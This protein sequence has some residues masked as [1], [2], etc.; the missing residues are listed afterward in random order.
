MQNKTQTVATNTAKTGTAFDFWV[1]PNP[2]NSSI[3]IYFDTENTKFT[4]S[5]I[6]VTNVLGQL[7]HSDCVATAL[8]EINLPNGIYY[9]SVSDSEHIKTV[10]VVVTE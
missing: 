9:V 2:T 10:K 6:S 1:R 7:V 8:Y 3:K 5:K 4:N